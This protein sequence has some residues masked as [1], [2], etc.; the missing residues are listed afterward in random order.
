ML[1]YLGTK[2]DDDHT[3]SEPVMIGRAGNDYLQ[4]WATDAVLLRGGGGSDYLS[5]YYGDDIIK[6][7]RGAD[8]LSGSRG[9]DKLFGGRGSDDLWG[10]RESDFLRG[11]KGA[12][13]FHFSV[14]EVGT[15][16]DR[17]GD[18]KPGKD[19]VALHAGRSEEDASLSYDP[20]TGNV[21]ATI[22][23]ETSVI[24]KMDA[25]LALHDGDLLVV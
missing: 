7:G 14:L 24:A 12:D 17:I 8:V 2:R 13:T 1:K 23:H 4:T 21:S 19:I 3:G 18:F 16:V 5:G 20:A 10:G 6:G 9:Q 25:G 15:G 22:N 11:G